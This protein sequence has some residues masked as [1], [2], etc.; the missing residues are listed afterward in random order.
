MRLFEDQYL[1][2]FNKST[3]LSNEVLLLSYIRS[4]KEEKVC[5]ELLF[6]NNLVVDDTKGESIFITIKKYTQ[7]KDISIL[8]IL[9]PGTD[10]DP[11]MTRHHKGFITHLKQV[12]PNILTIYCVL[13]RQHLVAYVALLRC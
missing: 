3:L 8:N 13:H 6:A 1:I 12:V 5:Q 10:D 2:Q 11:A 4:I 7:E 9:S